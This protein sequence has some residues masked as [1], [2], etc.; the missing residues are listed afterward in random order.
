VNFGPPIGS[1]PALIIQNDIGNKFAP[2]VIIATIT[3]IPSLKTYPTDVLLAD[4]ILPKKNSRVLTSTILTI[5]KENLEDY[6]T[7]LP[8]EIMEKVDLALMA[9]L[10]LEK[11]IRK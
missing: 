8:K 7:V 3:S 4:G 10:D 1:R 9:S 5:L 2:T 11:Y 6:L